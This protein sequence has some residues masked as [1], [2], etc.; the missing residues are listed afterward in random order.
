M[1]QRNSPDLPLLS[2]AV[3]LLFVGMLILASVSVSFSLQNTGTT[4]YYLNHQLLLGLLPGLVAA[5]IAFF[6]PLPFIRKM[7]LWFLLFCIFL[8]ALVFVPGIGS[9]ET[10][11]AHRWLSA[12]PFSFQPAELLKVAFV[13][14]LASWLSAK[15]K[16]RQENTKETLLPFAAMMGVVSL[17]LILQPDIGTL[18]VIAATG[19]TMYFLA[20]TPLWHAATLVGIGLLALGGLVLIAPYRF[21]R[22]AVFLNPSLDPLGQGYQVKQAL[23]G[24]GSGGLAGAGLGLSFQKFGVLPEPISDSI[25]AVFA[26]ET[27]FL[28][29]LLLI[30]LIVAFAWRG[31]IVSKRV[32][33]DQFASL[34]AAGIVSW[35][36]LQSAVNIAAMIGLLPLTGIPLPF[37]SYG[38]SAL[39]SE[40]LAVG[41]LL[42]ISKEA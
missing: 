5:T 21:S 38:G 30:G 10:G 11:G 26:E 33:S 6:T 20:G 2:L 22:F 23:I 25:F 29:G 19:L 24:I 27:G 16:R 9:G 8:L 3:A 35:I 4:F 37:V 15:K 1:Q 40:L 12:G 32:L 36:F 14:Y 39:F 28:G 42:N 41:I 18:A 17:F 13:L 34:A 31:L 7:S